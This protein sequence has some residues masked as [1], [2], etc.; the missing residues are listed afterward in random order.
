[1]APFHRLKPM[2]QN[3]LFAAAL[4][5]AAPWK[6]IRSGLQ[7]TGADAK[8]LYVDL[9]FE[10]GG[11]FPC[12]KCAK[13]CGVY[14]SE[15]KRWRHLNF[16]QYATFLSARVPR[17][18]CPEH[19][20]LQVQVPWARPGSGFTLM[21]EAMVMLLA[22]DMPVSA[23]ADLTGE[24]DTRLWRVIRHYV[25]EAH[26]HQDWSNLLAVAVD[27][28]ATR[29]GHRYATVA[30]D[31]DLGH[32][33]PAR[34]LFMT[35]ERSAKC[36][37]E[38]AQAMSAH[39]ATPQQIRVAAI[40]MSPAYRLGVSEHLPNAQIVFDRFHVM[41]MA[42]EAVDRV[43]KHLCAQGADMTGALWALRGNEDSL[44]SKHR[45]RREQLCKRHKALGRA[46]AMRE[47]L[48]KTWECE[49]KQDAEI[50]LKAWSSWATRSRQPAFKSLAKTIK[51]HW[52][53]ILAFFPYR[54]TSAAIE[55]ING[56]IQAARRRARGFR[57]FANLRAIAYWMAGDL[58]LKIP[59]PFVHPM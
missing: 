23:I 58:D 37:G 36:V 22:K 50:H 21:F 11:K 33:R 28:T 57:N 34:L 10:E 40:D 42:G 43:R 48:Q 54:I 25:Q 53:G 26:N 51:G 35:P 6:V 31:L 46:L 2:D 52:D 44:S 3:T 20:V 17:I 45:E 14:D 5:L 41:K 15:V 1:M 7:D 32:Q 39:G 18:N 13:L 59:S 27:E 8:V 9:D 30:V 56:V 12:P 55:A 24:H 49:N 16:W 29:K 19:K 47:D 38:F 4:Q